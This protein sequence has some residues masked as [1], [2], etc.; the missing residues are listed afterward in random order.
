[1][2]KGNFYFLY[3]TIA[4]SALL[5]SSC[6]NWLGN[7]SDKD[8]LKGERIDIL[9]TKESLNI[10]KSL[11]KKEF[12][13]GTPIQNKLW[14][15]S[16]LYQLSE[17]NLLI[18]NGSDK[19]IKIDIGDA[20]SSNQ[21]IST[22][23][24]ADGKIITIDAFGHISAFDINNIKNK[25]W[26]YNIASDSKKDNKFFNAAMSYA[27]GKIFVST[28]ELSIIAL[29]AKNGQLLWSRKLNNIVNSPATISNGNLFVNTASSNLYSLNIK[30]GSLNWTASGLPS[31]ITI[32]GGVSPISAGRIILVPYE[33]G[34]VVALDALNGNQIWS[35]TISN[36]NLDNKSHLSLSTIN[37]QP[38]IYNNLA[39]ITSG[40]S[41]IVAFDLFKGDIVWKQNISSNYTPWINGD[42]AY[43]LDKKNRL[44]SIYLPNGAIKFANSLPDDRKGKNDETEP[45]YWS[46]PVMANSKL[47]LVG[48]HGN[49]VAISPANGLVEKQIKID[50]GVKLP[51]IIG[52]GKMFLLK[53][54]ADLIEI[55]F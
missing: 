10:D 23:L 33:S 52:Y 39:I 55:S 50:S 35:N 48:S 3:V 54:N 32:I 7:N 8:K 37:A 11:V 15:K 6:S 27:E 53:S 2:R 41:G 19:T 40:D 28:G 12:F 22:P 14:S 43:I 31:E 20:D 16:D 44:V 42:Y 46:G 36:A 24:I 17:Q 26:D 1:M 38:V 34:E 21:L 25:I 13:L 47:W 51:P 30:D 29:D 45:Y 18:T 49:L 9:N 4:T 5:L